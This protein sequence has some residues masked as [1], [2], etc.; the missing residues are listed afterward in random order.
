MIVGA[1]TLNLYCDRSGYGDS[2]NPT[3]PRDKL[4]TGGQVGEFVGRTR[5]DTIAQAR[6]CG[7]L[8]KDAEDVCLCPQCRKVKP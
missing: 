5:T 3:C 1:Y 8:V 7:W 4:A 6:R 2:P